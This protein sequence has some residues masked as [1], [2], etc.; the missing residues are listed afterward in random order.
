MTVGEG[1]GRSSVVRGAAAESSTRSSKKMHIDRL[2]EA[3]A[4]RAINTYQKRWGGNKAP[5]TMQDTSPPLHHITIA[6]S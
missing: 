4:T 5:M 1:G 6:N 3:L 2:A